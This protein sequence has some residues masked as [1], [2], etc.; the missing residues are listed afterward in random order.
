MQRRV[1]LPNVSFRLFFRRRVIFGG[2]IRIFSNGDRNL[3][4]ERA[5]VGLSLHDD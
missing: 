5:T 4:G 3:R 1:K 2:G